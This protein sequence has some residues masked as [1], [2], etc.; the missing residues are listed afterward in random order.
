MMNVLQQMM[1]VLMIWMGVVGYYSSKRVH[2]Q[3]CET[4]LVTNY[5]HSAVHLVNLTE[6]Q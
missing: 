3:G 5:C 2:T 1:M 6:T 4:S